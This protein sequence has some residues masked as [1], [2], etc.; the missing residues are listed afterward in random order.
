V[1]LAVALHVETAIPNFIIHEYVGF[2]G[3]PEN[4]DLLTPDLEIKNGRFTVPEG[5]GLGIELNEK[6]VA[7]YLCAIVS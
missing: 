2:S 5:P 4:R 6:A 3:L 7:K 1:T